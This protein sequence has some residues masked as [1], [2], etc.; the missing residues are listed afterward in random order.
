MNC[1]NCGEFTSWRYRR[2][3]HCQAKLPEPEGPAPAPEEPGPQPV[4]TPAGMF[5]FFNAGDRMV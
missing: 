3:P 4:P 2:C 5:P 1:P